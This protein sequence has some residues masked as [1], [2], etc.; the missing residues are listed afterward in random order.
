MNRLRRTPEVD[1]TLLG[2]R[3]GGGYVRS[4]YTPE[5]PLCACLRAWRGSVRE[6]SLRAKQ[7]AVFI[8][9]HL[10]PLDLRFV[11]YDL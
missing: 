10:R 1:E 2:C 3:T 4:V 7:G 6:P 11:I 8:S 9:V 5:P